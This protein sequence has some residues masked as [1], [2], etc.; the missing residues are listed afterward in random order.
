MKKLLYFF[1][2][3]SNKWPL[4]NWK[5]ITLCFILGFIIG[6]TC[7]RRKQQAPEVVT[8]SSPTEAIKQYADFISSLDSSDASSTDSLILLANAWLEIDNAASIFLFD[9]QDNLNEEYDSVYIISRARAL[10]HLSTISDRTERSFDDLW[11]C[12]SEIKT[13]LPDDSILSL[14]FEYQKLYAEWDTV[15]ISIYSPEK[16]VRLYTQLLDDANSKGFKSESELLLFLHLEDLMFRNYLA[17]LSQCSDIP[18]ADLKE[19]SSQIVSTI[20]HWALDNRSMSKEE[21]M[22]LMTI[23]NTRRLIQNAQQ[24]VYD[25]HNKV[26]LTDLMKDAYSIMLV[27]PWVSIEPFA[28]S[29]LDDTNKQCLESL[30]KET[31]TCLRAI[32]QTDDEDF[33]SLPTLLTQMYISTL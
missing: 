23:R 3:P 18:L 30:A 11:R 1:Y 25:I 2:E 7:C 6:I 13:E 10:D 19:K 33:N 21:I 15:A 27:Q 28:F 5:T 14:A 12:I 32:S 9:D 26:E 16:T 8:F 29:M 17:V 4:V 31:S 24:C 22:T 20:L